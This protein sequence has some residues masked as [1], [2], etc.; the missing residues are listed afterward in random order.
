MLFIQLYSL[1]TPNGV[2]VTI[3][4]EALLILFFLCVLQKMGFRL[5]IMQGLM[6]E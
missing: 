6:C 2:K 3:L 5:I 4:F 1:A